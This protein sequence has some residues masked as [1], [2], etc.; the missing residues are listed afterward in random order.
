[1]HNSFDVKGETRIFDRKVAVLGSIS[2]VAALLMEEVKTNIFYYTSPPSYGIVGVVFASLA[3]Y[4]ILSCIIGCLLT[5]YFATVNEEHTVW[6]LP[7][8]LLLFFTL[9]FYFVEAS[10]MGVVDSFNMTVPKES[11]V[12]GPDS[13]SLMAS[14]YAARSVPHYLFLLFIVPYAYFLRL[15]AKGELPKIEFVSS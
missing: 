1:M 3:Y 13:D 15:S 10:V 5:F 7:H 14:Y 4:T 12:P 8:V 2:V 6:M 9:V 11:L